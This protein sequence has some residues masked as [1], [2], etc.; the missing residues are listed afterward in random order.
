MAQNLHRAL[1]DCQGIYDTQHKIYSPIP[2]QEDGVGIQI[3][4][5]YLLIQTQL[6]KQKILVGFCRAVCMLPLREQPAFQMTAF[7]S[8]ILN[9]IFILNLPTIQFDSLKI[10]S[11]LFWVSFVLAREETQFYA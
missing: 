9:N 10:H 6:F 3:M 7:K 11:I 5:F 1:Q 2:S 4:I 8:E